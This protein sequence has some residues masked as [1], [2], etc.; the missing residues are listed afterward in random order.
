ML[1]AVREG[2]DSP[3]L[4][5]GLQ[6]LVLEPLGDDAAAEVLRTRHPE[7]DAD[8]RRQ[9]LAAAAGNP[10]ALVELPITLRGQPR[11]AKGI[12]TV[13]LT[14]DLER[15][16]A[17]RLSELEHSTQTA[18]I[19]AAANDGDDVGEVIAATARML[20]NPDVASGVLMPAVDTGLIDVSLGRL[21]FRHPLTRSAIYQAAK[22]SQRLAAHAALGDLLVDNPDRRAW[23]LAAGAAAPDEAV[24]AELE[25]AGRSAD[26]RGAPAIS[27]AAWERAATLTPDDVRRGPRLLRAAELLLDLGQ[28]MRATELA[29][30]AAPLLT[31]L[32]YRARLAL[33]R[34]MV[35][36]GTPG[37][38][39]RIR[40]LVDLALELL[41]ET[42][43]DLGGRLLLAAGV[44]TWSADPGRD[45]RDL[46]LRSTQQLP[47]PPDDPRRLTIIGYTDPSAYGSV[48]L[49]RVLQLRPEELDAGTSELV[50]SVYLTGADATIAALQAKVVDD[51]RASGALEALPR[52]LTMQAWRAIA[53]ADWKIAV[54]AVDEA[55]RIAVETRQ[56][57]WEAAAMCGQAMITA[58]RGDPDAANQLAQQA[59]AVVLP[60]RINAVLCGIQYVRGVAAIAA[61]RYEEALGQLSRMFDPADPAFQAVQSTWALG[62][63]AEAAAHTGRRDDARELLD[64]Y[65]R[66]AE[67]TASPWTSAAIC[68]ARPLLA[69][70]EN[71][72]AAFREA[73]S[74][75]L[76]HWP[77]YRA[78][79]LLE[80]GR[81]LRRQRRV[82]EARV[83]LRAARDSCDA[84]GLTSWAR[85]ARQE[86]RATGEAS[87]Q[88]SAEAWA[89]LSPQELQIARMAAV[90]LSNRE[91]GQRLYLSHRTV[92]SHLYRAFPKL[93]I[94]SR[95][96]LPSVLHPTGSQT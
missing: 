90:G 82:A 33:V 3:L 49:D 22:A 30:Q 88:A 83:P 11:T 36:P 54:P 45:A 76:S 57:L 96:Q 28:P 52:V 25:N 86:L 9:V 70:D 35:D 26:Q 91:I 69:D 44:R 79:L 41:A 72:D 95:S 19:A 10:L 50:M 14:S 59:E 6:R 12:G 23:H 2:Y 94:T 39:G 71:A 34:E 61:G 7:L 66:A 85:R 20:G 18:L 62:D 55:A 32:A 81:W 51:V 75:Q 87:S 15:S 60:L 21:A 58:L 65:T 16:Y 93:G 4:E 80:Q 74:S 5:A 47:V 37:D 84:F 48:I 77:T 56:P 27:A 89:S 64:R 29:T 13:S 31:G 63:L 42:D 43:V 92:G 68:Y 67:E 8:T 40:T 1:V 38:P 78:R 53:M 24:A 73:L 17:A 46:V